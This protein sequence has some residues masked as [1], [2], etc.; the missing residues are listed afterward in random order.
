MKANQK[1]LHRQILSQFQG[2]RHVPF[3]ATDHEMR[4]SLTFYWIGKPYRS[5]KK[6]SSCYNGL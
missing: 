4:P 2:K 3:V 5:P 6:D 1:T